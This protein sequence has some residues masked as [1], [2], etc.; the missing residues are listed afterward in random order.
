MQLSVGPSR[1]SGGPPKQTQGSKGGCRIPATVGKARLIS[2]TAPLAR[3]HAH[4]CVS[5]VTLQEVQWLLIPIMSA[6]LLPPQDSRPWTPK[7]P[8]ASDA[9][10]AR[11]VTGF[12]LRSAASAS[13]FCE[14][15][16]PCGA[17]TRLGSLAS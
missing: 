10:C 9:A 4:A 5:C 16:K 7:T 3:Q 15:A 17:T 12:D 13:L 14:G 1:G 8:K 6:I 11:V 2:A